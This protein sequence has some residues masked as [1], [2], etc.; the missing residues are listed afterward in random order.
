MLGIQLSEGATSDDLEAA[1]FS[2]EG[3][4][5]DEIREYH[6]THLS[7]IDPTARTIVSNFSSPAARDA[8]LAKK[9]SHHPQ[10]IRPTR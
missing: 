9:L 5:T 7:K 8:K 10:E 6:L 4:M 2:V 3:F 1:Y